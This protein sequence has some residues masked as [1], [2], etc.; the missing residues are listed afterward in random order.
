MMTDPYQLFI[1]AD[2]GEHGG[3]VCVCQ[4]DNTV[5]IVHA[6]S[7][8]DRGDK[9]NQDFILSVQP[10][11][12]LVED[13]PIIPG[14]SSQH[15]FKRQVENKCAVEQYLDHLDCESVQPRSWQS[16][17][18]LNP[19]ITLTKPQRLKMNQLYVKG[20]TGCLLTHEG[21]IDAACIALAGMTYKAP[22]SYN[23]S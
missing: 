22:G 7:W 14:K 13:V 18:G 15:S 21:Q 20:K 6:F 23:G 19:K 9:Y 3:I 10:Q 17:L 8:K 1:G 5:R 2:P 12:V 16:V 4:Y 11:R